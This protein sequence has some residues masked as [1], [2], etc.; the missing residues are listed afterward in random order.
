MVGLSLCKCIFTK[1]KKKDTNFLKHV[2]VYF[3]SE[4]GKQ[5]LQNIYLKKYSIYLGVR[6]TDEKETERHRELLPYCLGS[7]PRDLQQLGAVVKLP[8]LNWA[9]HCHFR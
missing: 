8:R 2:E 4:V 6:I 9:R 1:K 7:L 5:S 3:L